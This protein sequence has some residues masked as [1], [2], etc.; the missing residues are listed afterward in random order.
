[1]RRICG[2]LV[3]V[4]ILAGG[5]FGADYFAEV[6]LNGGGSSITVNRDI[7]S[8]MTFSLDLY[9]ETKDSST[10][11]ESAEMR[12]RG[13]TKS[14]GAGYA[15]LLDLIGPAAIEV[16]DKDGNPTG[17]WQYPQYTGTAFSDKKS[18]LAAPMPFGLTNAGDGFECGAGRVGSKIPASSFGTPGYPGPYSY[19]WGRIKL[20]TIEV[21]VPTTVPG[22]ATSP[23]VYEIAGSDS[24][25]YWNGTV[26]GGVG[27]GKVELTVIPEPA[28]AL[29]LLGVIPFLRRRR[30]A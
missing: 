14:D 25:F 2:V 5:A 4:A 22:T 24:F 28:T 19:F 18:G 9:V 27:D 29:L 30:T 10:Y 12:I 16:T 6:E 23:G 8:S 15:G 13:T 17:D 11:S 21:K 7:P 1:M 26:A 3:I 20:A